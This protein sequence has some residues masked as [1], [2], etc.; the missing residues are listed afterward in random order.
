[1]KPLRTLN[2]L[3]TVTILDPRWTLIQKTLNAFW[4][5]RAWTR[6]GGEGEGTAEIPKVIV[7][8]YRPPTPQ[9]R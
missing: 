8:E 3:W 2:R 1:M 9:L 6:E 7:G 4:D 5:S